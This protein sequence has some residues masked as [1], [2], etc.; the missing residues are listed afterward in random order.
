MKSLAYLNKY[1][2]KYKWHVFWGV[3]FIIAANIFA[4]LMPKVVDDAIDLVT[5][6]LR[7]AETLDNPSELFESLWYDALLL[8]GLYIL[9]SLIKG[10][11]TF[12]QRQT[13]IIMSRHIEF[14]LKNEI[15]DHY[16]R[17]SLSF[18]KRNKTGDIMNRISEDVSKV[19]MY[20]G[21]GI[22]YTINLAVLFLT[23][24][25]YMLYK[26]VEL[27][28]YVLSPLPV[29]TI[30]IYYVS[31][32]INKK[33]ELVQRKQSGLSTFVQEAFSGIRVIKAYNREKYQV[34]AFEEE[35]ESYKDASVSLAKTQ[36][37]FMP[38]IMVL[39]G[40]S[41]ILT[42]YIGGLKVISGELDYGDIAQFVIYINMLTWPFASVGWI[43]SI[44]Q[45]AAASQE[46]INEFLK[47]KT[48]IKNSDDAKDFVNGDIAFNNVSF[49]YPDSGIKALK[50]VSFT[51]EKNKITAFTG[52]IG[53]GKSTI[54]NLIGRLY[55]TSKGSISINGTDIKTLDLEQLRNAIGY[56]PQEVF[57]FSDSIE[58][59]ISFG[60][61]STDENTEADIIQAAKIAD[62]HSN[63][64]EFKHQY[65]TLLGERGITL[66]GGQKQRVSIARS[67]LRKA[68]ILIFDDCLSAVDTETE[69]KIMHN[70]NEVM[71]ERTS[72]IISHRISS[73]K[74]AD[75]IIVL[76]E[77]NII[78]EGSHKELINQPGLYKELYEKQLLA[79][80]LA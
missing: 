48:E 11:F 28:L 12:F 38:I 67:V 26:N 56:V 62:V 29:L 16:Q 49:E 13:I 17:L 43:T 24:V 19:R 9:Y 69:E 73:I 70:M 57:L 77:G 74:N 59:N 2:R 37:F 15:Y 8:G 71:K 31:N 22:M 18:Y 79:E 20:L 40:L 76:D 44:I 32:Q 7:Q 55:D 52:K 51:I 10:L 23:V 60:K 50:G 65:K 80:K 54:A 6:K 36:A 78:Q 63:I 25:P 14:D 61:T 21:P 47:E 5:D 35:A 34:N 53:S 39:I 33:S 45:R 1:L 64:I 3:I 30:L 72:V 4:V 41:T 66:S 58:N 42:I 68:P 27:T 75:K 46:R